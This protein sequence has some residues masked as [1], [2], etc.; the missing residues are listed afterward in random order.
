M[1]VS[2]L[3]GRNWLHRNPLCQYF[4][5]DFSVSH[6]EIHDEQGK[7][8]KAQESIKENKN[9]F[10][11]TD[12]MTVSSIRPSVLLVTFCSVPGRL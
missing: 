7:H 8:Y 11:H 3:Q 1:S 5:D 6:K 10:H 12:M 2:S 9:E 4:R